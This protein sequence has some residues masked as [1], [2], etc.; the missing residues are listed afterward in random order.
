M[1]LVEITS[2]IFGDNLDLLKKASTD[3]AALNEVKRSMLSNEWSEALRPYKLVSDDLTV[4]DDV[5]MMRGR[6]VVPAKLRT[7][8]MTRAH[9]SHSNA[10]GMKHILRKSLWW[11]SL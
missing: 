8:A 5:V 4:S 6:P 7:V 9:K 10:A 3:D 1:N 2:D 11:P